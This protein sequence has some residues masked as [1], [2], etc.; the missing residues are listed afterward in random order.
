M[1]PKARDSASSVN[2]FMKIAF[3]LSRIIVFFS[4]GGWG[5]VVEAIK[6]K[7][8]YKLKSTCYNSEGSYRALFLA[9]NT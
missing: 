1:C 4:F 7:M 2:P 3:Q 9:V 8:E 6:Y 5:K